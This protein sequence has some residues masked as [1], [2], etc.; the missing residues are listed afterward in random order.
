VTAKLH[1]ATAQVLAHPK[2]K[3][4]FS[5]LGVEVVGSTPEEFATFIKEDLDRWSKVIKE[6]DV[7]VR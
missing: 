5:R 4:A 7:K 2:V 3:E 1:G 6:A